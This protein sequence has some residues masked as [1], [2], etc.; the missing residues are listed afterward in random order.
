MIVAADAAAQALGLHPG[1]TVAHACA[2]VPDLR[3]VEADPAADAADLARLAGWCL[4][5]Y[6]PIVAVDPPAG[7]FID[8]TGAT[9]LRGGEAALL[10][11]LLT[12]LEQT[13]VAARAALADTA[14]AAHA[15]A[16][17]AAAG[18]ITVVPPGGSADALAPLP[19]AALRLPRAVCDELRR[20]GLERIGQ[21]MAMPRAP[22]AHRFGAPVLLRLDEALGRAAEPIDPLIPAELPAVR[23][24]FAEPIA[25]PEQL[26]R[27]IPLLTDALCRQLDDRS[28]GARRLDLVFH[29]LDH[30]PQSLRIGTSRPSRDPWHLARLLLMKLETIDP[31]CGVEVVTLTASLAEPLVPLQLA[32]AVGGIEASLHLAE[33]VD[34]LGNRLGPGRVYRL[35]PVE[36]DIPERS[37]RRVPALAPATGATWPAALPRP[38]RLLM[39]PEP[40]EA[41]A[42]LPDQP[43]AL[44]VWRRVRHRVRAADGPERVYGEWWRSAAET[45]LVRDYFCV[46]DQAGGRF[47]L[48]RSS[49]GFDPAPA[50]WRWYVHGLFG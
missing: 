26:Q 21:L 37:L 28:L 20:L 18:P 45:A 12:H 7:L 19:I 15:V 41:V 4:Q 1:L 16:R 10:A 8:V 40:V 38:A 30:Y 34:R 44:F 49:D 14:A 6:S 33:L 43:P 25:T 11:D 39:P 17:F 3:V 35:A 24:V 31:G 27:V 42:L 32:S 29:R 13:G 5:R 46:E 9:H 47:W 2:R 36:S 50:A 22:L 48:F 23:R